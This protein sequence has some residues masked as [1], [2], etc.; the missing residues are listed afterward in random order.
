MLLHCTNDV[1]RIGDHAEIIHATVKRLQEDNLRFSPEA[2]AEYDHLHDTLAELAS[3]T[4]KMLEEPSAEYRVEAARLQ[5]R[6]QMMLDRSE[7]EHFTRIS[8]GECKPHVGILFL[9]LIEEIR[10]ISR[11]LENIHER[12]AMFYGKFPKARNRQQATRNPA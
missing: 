11:H 2:E 4:I 12:A 6:I 8:N 5:E 1:E 10:K 3:A 7:T 9:E